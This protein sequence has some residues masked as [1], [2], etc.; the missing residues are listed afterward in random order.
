M[1]LEKRAASPSINDDFKTGDISEIQSREELNVAVG[2]S[3]ESLSN[4]TW[5]L[6][7]FKTANQSDIVFANKGKNTCIGID[8][9]TG[10][11]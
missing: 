11:Y 6:W 10:D 8:V 1:S 3:A 5:N 9:I 2:L 4:E 7:L